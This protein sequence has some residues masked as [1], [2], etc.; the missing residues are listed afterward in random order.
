MTHFVDEGYGYQDHF[1]F[2]LN[3]NPIKKYKHYSQKLGLVD[4]LKALAD[5]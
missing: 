4:R 5:S 2:I 3:I 1:D